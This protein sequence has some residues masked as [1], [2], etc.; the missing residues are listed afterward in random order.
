MGLDYDVSVVCVVALLH[1]TLAHGESTFHARFR[2]RIEKTAWSHLLQIAYRLGLTL[3]SWTL[4]F[5]CIAM[6]FSYALHSHQL[7][8]SLHQ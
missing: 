8:L 1:A 2:V 3:C 7:V 6:A 4:G 5:M